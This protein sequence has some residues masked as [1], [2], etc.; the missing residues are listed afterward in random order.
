MRLVRHQSSGRYLPPIGERAKDGVENGVQ[1]LGD[2]LGEEAKDEVAGFLQEPVFAAVAPA[3][4][5]NERLPAFVAA[6][7]MPPDH[8]IRDGQKSA[9]LAVSALDA[10]LLANIFGQ[11]GFG[12]EGL[13]PARVED[14]GPGAQGECPL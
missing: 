11:P 14:A 10:R 6:R 13:W 3:H 8:L 7:K 2:I 4:A 9:V 5:H 1:V 12:V